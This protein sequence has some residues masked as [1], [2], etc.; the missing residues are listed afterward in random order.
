MFK[1]I[2]HG[3]S[4]VMALIS[5]TTFLCC[6]L[7]SELMQN[8]TLIAEVKLR[9]ATTG[10]PV[11]VFSM[12]A[13]GLTGNFISK[14]GGKVISLKKRRMRVLALTGL[15]VMIPA[16][17]YLNHKAEIGEFDSYFYGVQVVEALLGLV[18]LRLVVMNFI[19]GI[20]LIKR[21]STI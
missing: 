19:A 2:V 5:I 13:V 8:Y 4:A 6:T 3:I 18:Q 20:R 11:L 16:A 21:K 14:R 7:F 12:I 1:T 17:L 15:F 10:I 9:I